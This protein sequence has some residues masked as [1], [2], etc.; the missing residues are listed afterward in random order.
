VKDVLT[1]AL[2][3]YVMDVDIMI[4]GYLNVESVGKKAKEINVISMYVIQNYILQ[5]H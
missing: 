1:S 4:Q 2:V 5:R 3:L